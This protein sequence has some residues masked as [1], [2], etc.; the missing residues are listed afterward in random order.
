MTRTTLALS[1]ALVACDAEPVVDADARGPLGGNVTHGTDA[2]TE[3]PGHTDPILP[4]LEP[5]EV[6]VVINEVMARNDSTLQ[7]DE[8]L[9]PDWIEIA[10]VGTSAVDL[11]LIEIVD[12]G[13]NSWSGNGDLAAG[14]R[15]LLTADDLGFALA[16]DADG[17]QIIANRQVIDEVSWVEL[18]RDVSLARTPDLSGA[19]LRTAWA[20]P[21]EPNG[22]EISPTLD[23]A[24]EHV[25]R[26]DM[27]HRIDFEMTQQAMN[28]I[29][30][31]SENWGVVKVTIDDW[32]I[33]QVGLRLKGSASFDTLDGKPA[34]KID[35]NRAVPGTRFKTLKGMNLH[36]GNVLDPTRA[37]DHISYRFAREGGIMAP[38]V[39]WADVYL[40]GNHYGIY[41]IIEQHDDVMIE[42]NFPGMGETGVMFEPNEQRGGGGGW[43]NDFGSG[44]T[45]SAW[46]YEEGPIP[47]DPDVMAALA[48]AD[49]LVGQQATDAR[50]AQ[51][52]DV[53]DQDNLLTYMAWEAIISHTDGY[54]A[55]NNWRVFIHPED[56]KVH[57]VPAG[58]EWTWDNN[59]DPLYWGGQLA[60]WC[61]E[62]N[63]C[64]RMYAE[65][66]L[67]MVLLVDEIGLQDDFVEVSTMLGPYIA[68]D[69]RSRHSMNTVGNDRESTFENIHDYPRD[70]RSDLCAAIEGLDGC[71][72]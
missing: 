7:T 16:S 32:E 34:F 51:L 26:R 64:K 4:T 49:E 55:P 24:T 37:R 20:S 15:L 23:A 71:T 35:F 45:T 28:T 14:Q 29:D 63:G 10:N 12:T 60:Q 13:G 69:D 54:K 41:M 59:S 17:L 40:N 44:N 30:S 31:R 6:Q 57:L 5:E 33:P 2:P 1:L 8:G 61:L 58:A 72:R 38:R 36:N 43:G 65:R 25:F 22:P 67:E 21:G 70:V 11:S 66:A 3:D 39:G 47:P 62:N 42:A 52:W 18:E 46:D 19:L 27:V 50:V 56:K 9:T 48:T 68:A 53:V